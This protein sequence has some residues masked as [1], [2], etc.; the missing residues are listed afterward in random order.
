MVSYSLFSS[1]SCTSFT[2]FTGKFQSRQGCE[3]Q[4]FRGFTRKFSSRALSKGPATIFFHPLR[5]RVSQKNSV[6]KSRARVFRL[7]G[8]QDLSQSG[9]RALRNRSQSVFSNLPLM[10]VPDEPAFLR[11]FFQDPNFY[12]FFNPVSGLKFWESFPETVSRGVSVAP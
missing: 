8:W 12:P 1:I 7:N 9:Y 10:A 4:S 11:Q 5:N 6:K 3:I 2:I